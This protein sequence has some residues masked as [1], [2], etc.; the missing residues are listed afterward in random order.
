MG[1]VRTPVL[2]LVAM[3]LAA[4][5]LTAGCGRLLAPS[6]ETEPPWKDTPAPFETEAPMPTADASGVVP[7]C[8]VTL[9]EARAAVPDLARGPDVGEPFKNVIGDCQF[10]FGGLS[11]GRP[12]GVGILVFDAE[13]QG[14]HLWDSVRTDPTFPNAT[15][16]SGLGDDAFVTGSPHVTDL[17]AVKGQIGLHIMAGRALTT[18]QL[19]ALAR[20]AFARLKP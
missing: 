13:G 17:W 7:G 19:A 10:W 18:E 14:L 1:S 5:L 15:D 6:T 8:P 12:D 2:L 9:A 4:A 20:A 11:I 16:I 3:A